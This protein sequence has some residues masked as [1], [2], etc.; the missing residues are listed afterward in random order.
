MRLVFKRS[1]LAEF[2]EGIILKVKIR[3]LGISIS[4]NSKVHGHR[5]EDRTPTGIDEQALFC[6][7]IFEQVDTPIIVAAPRAIAS[8]KPCWAKRRNR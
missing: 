4:I 2:I 6:R 8:L 1:F 5:I 7:Q 3:I